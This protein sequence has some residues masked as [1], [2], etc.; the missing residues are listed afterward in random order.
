MD[1]INFITPLSN[2][3]KHTIQSWYICTLIAI[4]S[5][6]GALLFI[7]FNQLST[8]HTYHAQKQDLAHTALPYVALEAEFKKL[9]S[10][11]NSFR[12]KITAAQT[13][14][15]EQKP[16]DLLTELAQKL[17]DNIRFHTFAYK[18]STITIIG[19]SATT[20]TL[21]N[22]LESIKEYNHYT[23]SLCSLMRITHND[24]MYWQFT[25]EGHKLDNIHTS[26]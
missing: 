17:P 15:N 24:T 12:Q 26:T 13:H 16:W 14:L 4:L 11:K 9:Q 10:E 25:I 20:A 23:F 7:S 18:L 3:T 1:F 6:F 8:L 5:T 2:N 22:Y 19:I 21:M